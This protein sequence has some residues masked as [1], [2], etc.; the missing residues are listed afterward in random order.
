[1][2]TA[3]A[4]AE[5]RTRV[6]KYGRM[7]AVFDPYG[8]IRPSGLGE[9]GIYF[10]GTRFLSRLAVSLGGKPPLFLS[11]G[12][13]SDNSLFTA[14]LTNVDFLDE[15]TVL[16]A[17]GTIHLARSKLLL[18]DTCYEQLRI[19]N[20]AP[21]HV[22]LPV[23]IHFAADF[24]D[25]FE[26][27]GVKR[28]QH[29]E[30]L[31]DIL[32]ND[33]VKMRYRG[34]DN[35]MRCTQMYCS[36][37]PTDLS[38]SHIVFDADLQPRETAKFHVS[39]SCADSMTASAP[40]HTFDSALTLA[41]QD[42]DEMQADKCSVQSANDRFNAWFSRSLSDLNMMTIGNPEPDY[43]YA[44]VPWFSTVFGR[45]GIITA[46]ES[47]WLDSRIAKGVLEYLAVT[48]ATSHIPDAEAEPGK[49]V[50]ETREGE[51]AALGEVPFRRYYGSVDSTPL[52]IMLAGA[53]YE[54]TADLALVRALWPNIERALSW[55][56]NYGDLDGDGFVEYQRRSSKG[57]VQQGWK[58]SSDSVF[59]ADGSLAEPPIALCEVQGYVYAAKKHA[60]V[61]ARA[62]G[63][64]QKATSL[65]AEA[66]KLQRSFEQAFW[67]KDLS[68]YALALDSRK[69]PCRVRTS[70]AGHCLYTGV[71]S[72]ERAKQVAEIL[73]GPDFYS[74]WG[75]RTVSSEE[76]K[77]NPLSYHNGSV[78]PH[79]NALL[80]A[81]LSRYG[82]T[83]E[84]SSILAAIF[85]AS[86]FFELNRLPELLCGLHK[87]NGE[88][89]TLYPVACSPQAWSA[90]AP[91]LLLSAS[92]G[93]SLNAQQ[94]CI[95]LNRPSLP[96]S[97]PMVE[98]HGLR[99]G[100]AAVDLMFA[101]KGDDVRVEVTKKT[102]RVDVVVRQ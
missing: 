54:R 55:I 41:V 56:D 69:Q 71:A 91:F 2:A 80:A 87:R 72:P 5:E 6:L 13:R 59:H 47:L 73:L 62:L 25:V 43:P 14:D 9:H 18:G 61:L 99:L 67:C 39:I 82:L 11:S 63:D 38:G 64:S 8:D 77:Y 48:Q 78:W 3:W 40:S 7:F 102:G 36:P 10:G 85:E 88:G 37:M 32:Q 42:A 84:A 33:R 17:R 94:G 79:D 21:I 97:V 81:G 50:H 16:L 27:R 30:R 83:R 45:D 24:V 4:P 93:L 101:R 20:Y 1:M 57:L 95:E 49:I 96:G 52:F 58:D 70:N 34:A 53:Y 60:A 76:K 29:G 100:H 74:G 92:L 89:P 26:V 66:E 28:T 75:V 35:V 44:G 65:D 22:R 46:L 68:T 31:P 90:A 12:V 23:Q 15:D 51:M 19:T 86:T 98:I